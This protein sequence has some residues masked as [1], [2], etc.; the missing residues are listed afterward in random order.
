MN[1]CECGGGVRGLE[2]LLLLP[3]DNNEWGLAYELA[4]LI[5]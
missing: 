5:N 3:A 1:E 2:L 4:V